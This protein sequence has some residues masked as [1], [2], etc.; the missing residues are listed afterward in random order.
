[1]IIPQIY[2][3]FVRNRI[4]YIY[5]FIVCILLCVIYEDIIWDSRT[6]K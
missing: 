4:L 5:I 2:E 3:F 6:K 1:M